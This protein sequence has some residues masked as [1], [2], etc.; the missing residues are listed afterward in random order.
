MN[1][2]IFPSHSTLC[3]R[4]EM[5]AEEKIASSFS[6]L[7]VVGRIMAL[8]YVHFL[9]TKICEYVEFHGKGELGC[10]GIMVVNQMTLRRGNYSGSS[11]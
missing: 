5:R 9:I 7:M 4:L 1:Q 10:C 11:R 3:Y 6:S 8:K 2:S